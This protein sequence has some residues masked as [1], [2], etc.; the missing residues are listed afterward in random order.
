MTNQLTEIY[1]K[2]AYTTRTNNYNISTNITMEKF[3]EFIKEK[4]HQDFNIN[5]ANNIEIVEAG[6]PH[7][8]NGRDAEL[9][10]A[11]FPDENVLFGEKYPVANNQLSAFYIRVI[12]IMIEDDEE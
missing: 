6:Q 9:A 3:L 8:V 11:L 4:V 1:L 2:L 12:P 7:N 10:P 5:I